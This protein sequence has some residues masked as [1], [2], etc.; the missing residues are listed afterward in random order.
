MANERTCHSTSLKLHEIRW[1]CFADHPLT[2]N[3]PTVGR[4]TSDIGVPELEIVLS[5]KQGIIKERIPVFATTD[6][7]ID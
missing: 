7:T 6:P 5:Y 3:G 2:M 1:Y 4:A